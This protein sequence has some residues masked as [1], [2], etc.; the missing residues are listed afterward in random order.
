MSAPEL[1]DNQGS[2]AIPSKMQQATTMLLAIQE[3]IRASIAEEVRASTKKDDKSDTIREQVRACIR[4]EITRATYS[5]IATSLHEDTVQDQ[6]K[7]LVPT[8]GT[9]FDVVVREH[10]HACLLEEDIGAIQKLIRDRIIDSGIGETVQWNVRHIVQEKIRAS[11]HQEIGTIIQDQ[12][13]ATMKKNIDVMI[14]EHVHTLIGDQLRASIGGTS[15]SDELPRNDSGDGA[16]VPGQQQ[17][18][19][20][21]SNL[22]QQHEDRV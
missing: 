22:G 3:Q 13:R 12:I 15:A 17:H 6:I 19:D 20:A 14:R 11:I 18:E 21:A 7:S 10:V 9:D 5:Q 16:S 8:L 2:V 4:E 1:N